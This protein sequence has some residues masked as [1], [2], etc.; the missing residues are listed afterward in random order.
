MDEAVPIPSDTRTPSR[1]D[2]YA[3][4]QDYAV[5]GNKRNA[6]LVALDGS[7]D[8]LCLPRFD[9]PSVFGALLDPQRAGAWTLQPAEP[10]QV[11][12][13]YVD[14][15]NV[16]ETTFET[17]GGAVRVTDAITRAP[18]RPIDWD[19]IVR[20]I[21]CIS[22]EVHVRWRVEPRFDYQAVHPEVTAEDGAYAMRSGTLQ[23]VLQGWDA[24][25]VRVADGGLEAETTLRE[26][27]SALLVLS[28]FD[29]RPLAM[30]QREE[31][32]RRLAATTEHWQR[33]SASADYSGEWPEAVVRSG[34]ALELL[35]CD[36]ESSMIAAVTSS[37]P[38]RVGG[39][40]N[41]DYRYAWVR[42]TTF[43]MDSLMRI[44]F[45]DAVHGMLTWLLH[46]ARRTHPRVHTFYGL[47]GRV[48][49][50]S[51]E[52]DWAGYRGSKPVRVGN[53]AGT[54][55]QLGNFGDLLQTTWLYV[56][57]GNKLDPG[58]G[59]QLAEVTNVLCHLW[60]NMD[61][62]IWELDDRRHYTQSK[63]AAWL[64]FHRA[65]DLAA[66]GHIP[67]DHVDLWRTEAHAMREFIDTRCFDPARGIWK[68]DSQTDELDAAVLLMAGMDYVS[69]D[70]ARLRATI[71]AIRAELGHGPLLYRWTGMEDQ[72]GCFLAC[73]FWLVEALA[74][75]GRREEAVALMDELVA[76]ANDVGLYSEELDPH[77]GGMLGNFPQALSHLSLISAA[78]ALE[79]GN[80]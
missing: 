10:F 73:S 60:R 74:R 3:P 63:L 69:P 22:G 2:G 77:T 41:Y 53:D 56:R 32:E 31:V 14:G 25:E 40:R 46:T 70:D 55:L 26:G 39:D 38:E 23:L 62:C 28:A 1:Q 20:R 71:D 24:G 66:N 44:G 52:L 50:Q 15:S 27:D 11:T 72:E 49:D 78:F 43:A 48:H 61:S 47:D 16:L 58:T 54:Q 9:A 19:E 18:T 45:P 29:D 17:E 4:I 33:W 30:S 34:L 65:L 57:A 8:W 7:I 35:I 75:T 6:A 79:G 51:R 68:R 64:C 67:A 76:L 12:R 13:R 59:L 80:A 36:P 5:I 42:D 21:D 37:L